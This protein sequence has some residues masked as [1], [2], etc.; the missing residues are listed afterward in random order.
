MYKRQQEDRE[1]TMEELMEIV[2]GPDFPTGATILGRR[3]I[4]QAYRLS[5]IHISLHSA[6]A[7]QRAAGHYI[8]QSP[9]KRRQA[10]TFNK[11]PQDS[12]A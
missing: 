3:A 10:I 12:V 2:K 9:A 11:R 1:T 5:L 4:E 7:R 6:I 8:Q